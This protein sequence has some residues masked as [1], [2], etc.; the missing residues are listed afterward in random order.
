MRS[1]RGFTLVELMITVALIGAL[2]GLGVPY[3]L[4][5]LPNIRVNAAVRQIVGDFRL[6]KTLAVER[7]VDCF[8]VFDVVGD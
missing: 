2:A 1:D 7:G 6:A 3:L 4:A 5:S 8:L